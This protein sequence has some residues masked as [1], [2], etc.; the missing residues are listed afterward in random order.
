MATPPTFVSESETAWNSFTTPKVGASLTQLANDVLVVC[1][2]AEDSSST[3][4][5][6]TG[7][8]LTYSPAQSIKIASYTA[9]SAWTALCTTQNFGVSCSESGGNHWG[10]N[11]LQFRGSTG[12]GA[13]AK[14][15]VTN[16]APSLSITTQ[17]DNSAIVVMVGDWAAVDGTT[18]TWRTG[19]GTLTEQSY[20]QDGTHYTIYCGYHADAGAAGAKT[21]GLT[22]PST[23]TYSIIA[24]EV[25]GTPASAPPPPRLR[26]M[27]HLLVR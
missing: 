3:L 1:A 8:S 20:F 6:P 10:A 15:N 27:Q 23:M 7:G 2:M 11:T 16:G 24:V 22:T 9:V 13:S 12:I 25:K 21:V 4:G 26:R 19:A 17:A 18:R 14:T 5:T